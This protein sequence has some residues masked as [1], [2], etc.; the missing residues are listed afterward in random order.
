MEA[1][2]KNVRMSQDMVERLE[3]IAR[4]EADRMGYTR[5]NVSPIVRRAVAQY[6]ENYKHPEERSDEPQR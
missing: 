6:I 4:A 2:I 5:P 1:L 3:A